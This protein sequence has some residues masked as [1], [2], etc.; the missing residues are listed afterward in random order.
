MPTTDY[1]KAIAEIDDRSVL[2][3]LEILGRSL[4][5]SMGVP[6]SQA[7][8]RVRGD[9]TLPPIPLDTVGRD[10]AATSDVVR[11]GRFALASAVASNDPRVATAAG[12]AIDEVLEPDV[13]LS[14]SWLVVGG[15]VLVALAIIGKVSYSAEAGW[16]VEPGLPG[17]EK[18]GEAVGRLIGAALGTKK[19]DGKP[20]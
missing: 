1:A 14:I 16:K 6:I 9:E 11:I 4:S 10:A 19:P 2:K 3:A 12:A 13:A 5:I 17:I 20:Q 8:R 15:A 18:A 7:D